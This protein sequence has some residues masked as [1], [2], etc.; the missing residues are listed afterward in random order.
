MVI[1]FNPITDKKSHM[2]ETN[3]IILLLVLV[4][5]FQTGFAQYD[6]LQINIEI[7][8]P[9]K[10]NNRLRCSLYKDSTSYLVSVKNNPM[11]KG[12][13]YETWLKRDADIIIKI[14]KEDFN[15]VAEK[16]IGLSSF[17]LL[18]GM[19]PSNPVIG[20]DGYGVILEIVVTV[21]K[22]SYSIWSPSRNTKE[23][24]LESFLTI[25]K[26]ILLLAKLK[27]KDYF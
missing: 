14:S 8:N 15:S 6:Y 23:R 9:N 16:V 22:I 10:K 25:C 1:I 2:I 21:D 19:N 12:D 13:N 17:E 7:H 27:P 24:N 18:K 4:T 20:N 5:C 26:G 11:F 3:K